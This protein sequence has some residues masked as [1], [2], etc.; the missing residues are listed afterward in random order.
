MPEPTPWGMK[1]SL[2]QIMAEFVNS[3][4]GGG[5]IHSVSFSPSGNK[6]CWVSHDSTINV[7]DPTK[8]NAVIRLLT[9]YLPFLSCIW[10]TE[11]SVVAAGHSCI[12]TVYVLTGNDQLMFSAKLDASEKKEMGG[13]SAMRK[14]QNLDKQSR[15]ESIDTNLNSIHQNA[16]SCICLY[17]GTKDKVTSISTSGLD[18]QLV[19]W[20]LVSLEKSIQGL[21]IM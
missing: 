12:P 10:I 4:S 15:S 19:L 9:E 11:N 16:I 8:S 3:P 13:M 21:K 17:K 1:M 20:D 18:G 2:G 6:I 7:A 5:W 14:F